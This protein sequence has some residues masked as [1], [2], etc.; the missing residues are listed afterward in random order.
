MQQH[1]MRDTS[2]TRKGKRMS[3][4]ETGNKA[5]VIASALHYAIQDRI[6]MIDALTPR[7]HPPAP[8]YVK[9]IEECKAMIRD[10]EKLLDK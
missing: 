2:L 3:K 9:Q 10:F 8:E 1:L 6:S 7:D 5:S 4:F